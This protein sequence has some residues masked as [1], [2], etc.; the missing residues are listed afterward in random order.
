VQ[1]KSSIICCLPM[2]INFTFLSS[3]GAPATPQGNIKASALPM[4]KGSKLF[5]DAI[6]AKGFVI[7]K[8]ID[9]DVYLVDAKGQEVTLSGHIRP[10]CQQDRVQLGARVIA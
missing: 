8:T 4:P 1:S 10:I 7:K 6:T 3:C 9:Q 2:L 5:R